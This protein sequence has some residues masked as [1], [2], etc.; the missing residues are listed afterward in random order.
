MLDYEQIMKITGG[1]R[2]GAE[3]KMAGES[4]GFGP[5]GGTAAHGGVGGGVC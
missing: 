1:K 2:D 3:E 4:A 5:G